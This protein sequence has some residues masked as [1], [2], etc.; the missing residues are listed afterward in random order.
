VTVW[1][2]APTLVQRTVSP[3]LTVMLAGRN[4]SST[5]WTLWTTWAFAFNGA[6]KT[7]SATMIK[8]HG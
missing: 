4:S 1:T 6:T 8:Y 2:L 5:A 3:T 7:T